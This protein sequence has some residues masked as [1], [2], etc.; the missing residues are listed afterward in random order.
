MFVQ[1]AIVTKTSQDSST[2]TIVNVT[3]ADQGMY[4]CVS[5][6]HLGHVSLLLV[7]S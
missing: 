7:S 5:G 2:L 3:V 1:N 4:A 6:N